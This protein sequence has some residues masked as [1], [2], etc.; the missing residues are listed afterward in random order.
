M[1][2][3][4]VIDGV[5]PPDRDSYE[6]PSATAAVLPGR[7]VRCRVTARRPQGS[8][9][10]LERAGSHT[11]TRVVRPVLPSSV[12][13]TDAGP[14]RR[15]VPSSRVPPNDVVPA[16]VLTATPAP[17]VRH[18]AGPRQCGYLRIAPGTAVPVPALDDARCR[19]RGV[20]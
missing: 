20:R 17:D 7:T 4:S 13:I 3:R 15:R 19:R 9:R 11:P 14:L 6:P 2:T 5:A 8:T 16:D 1:R 10:E 18:R 12:G